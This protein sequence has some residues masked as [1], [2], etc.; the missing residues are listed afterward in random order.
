MFHI[1][2]EALGDLTISKDGDLRKT[3]VHVHSS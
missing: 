3:A 2:P 1:D